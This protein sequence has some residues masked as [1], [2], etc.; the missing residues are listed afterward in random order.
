ME[1][2]QQ[3]LAKEVDLLSSSEDIENR[4][5]N[6]LK[7]VEIFFGVFFILAL[8]LIYLVTARSG[9]DPKEVEVV[10]DVSI[11]QPVDVNIISPLESNGALPVILQDQTT[12][13][14]DLYFTQTVGSPTVTSQQV[15]VDQT[16]V[17]VNDVSSISA[18]TYLGI[19]E[20]T[21]EKF[22][23]ADVLAVN[24]L[25][26]SLDTPFD[27]NFSSGSFVRPL[28]RNMNVD[29]SD[30]CK[31]FS[32]NGA[33]SGGVD[34]TRII[35]NI[36]TSSAVDLGKFGDINGGLL[37]GIVLRKTDG[38]YWN[39]WTAKTNGELVGLM[40]D[41]SFFDASNP[42]QGVNGLSGR[43][44]WGGQDKHG[45]VIRLLN[46]SESLD[47]IICDDLSGLL[48][49]KMIGAGSFTTS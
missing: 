14:V 19:F 27:H 20:V 9:A 30:E 32:V 29:G 26:V 3:H 16:W 41:V 43:F 33:Q 37:N 47:L 5:S 4:V 24:G 23:F 13:S 11:E 12:R 7:K 40:Y 6:S 28:T 46:S 48:D 21:E 36:V 18:G 8:I 49:F 15:A 38:N 42:G 25:N 34:I 10:S 22:Y 35:F 1:E 31:T 39:L 45:A 44:T 2:K 17:L